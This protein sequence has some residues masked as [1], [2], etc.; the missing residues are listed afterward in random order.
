MD[1]VQLAWDDGTVADVPALWLRDNCP[2]AEC[3]VVAKSERRT[4]IA[5]EPLDLAPVS[6]VTDT[7][8]VTVEWGSHTS[9][10]TLEWYRS[11]MIEV[12]RRADATQH[13]HSDLTIPTYRYGDLSETEAEGRSAVIKFLT[14]FSRYGVALVTGVP[15]YRGE[16]ER[17]LRRWAPARELP[18]GT[19]HDVLVNPLGYNIA[20]TSEALPPHNDFASYT[21]PPSGQILHMLANDVEGGDSILVDGWSIIERLHPDDI[22]VLSSFA[23]GFRQFDE[24]S[25]TWTC[26]PILRLAPDGSPRHIRFSNQL[27]QPIDPTAP[28]IDR[29]YSAYHRLSVLVL[30]P[31]HQYRF[32]MAEGDLLLLHG[33]RILH[34]RTAYEPSTGHRHLQDVYFEFEDLANKLYRLRAPMAGVA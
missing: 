33:H 1:S 23:V 24:T 5:T 19:V 4:M 2:C 34:G 8:G 11:I 26:A 3:K 31:E 6:V 13:W 28:D 12:E 10:Y 16:S 30:Q 27:M 22:D 9:L 21:W 7:R 18:F 14:S 20:H 25:E 15:C 32:R 17:F 29:F